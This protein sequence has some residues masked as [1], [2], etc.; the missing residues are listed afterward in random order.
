MQWSIAIVARPMFKEK[1][2]DVFFGFI[3]A[4]FLL[5]GF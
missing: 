2:D 5:A 1:S 4:L 3:G